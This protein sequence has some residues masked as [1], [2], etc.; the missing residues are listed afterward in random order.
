[1][2]GA[3]GE[4]GWGELVSHLKVTV[5]WD[6]A[7]VSLVLTYHDRYS[8]GDVP[9]AGLRAGFGSGSGLGSTEREGVW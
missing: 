6:R 9:V 8:G 1:M 5:T 2:A 4:A 7:H 3:E